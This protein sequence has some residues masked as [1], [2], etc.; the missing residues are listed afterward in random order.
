MRKT[1]ILIA[2]NAGV[3]KNTKKPVSKM[4]KMENYK[5]YIDILV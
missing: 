2:G 5:K 4:V 3:V 1:A